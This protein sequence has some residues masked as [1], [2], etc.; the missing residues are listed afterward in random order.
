MQSRSLGLVLMSTS[1]TDCAAF[2]PPQIGYDDEQLAVMQGG[3]A[4][5][6]VGCRRRNPCPCW[7]SSNPCLAGGRRLSR[8]HVEASRTDP[9]ACP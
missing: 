2:K 1:L 6:R 9:S 4:K 8:V 3:S 7:G 5:A